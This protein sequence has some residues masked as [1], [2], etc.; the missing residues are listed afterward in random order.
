MSLMSKKQGTR[1]STRAAARAARSRAME[2]AAKARATAAT[3]RRRASDTAA[4]FTPLA[5]NAR[6]TATR[7]MFRA[8]QWAAPRLDQA[9]QAVEKR[10]APGVADMLTAAARRIEPRTRRRRWPAFAAGIAVLAAAGG[11]AAVYLRSR[12]GQTG[13]Q[14]E[15][16]S[17]AAPEGAGSEQ[18]GETATAD[19]NGQVRTS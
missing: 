18:A 8:R 10:V 11:G 2:K 19:V 14:P 15:P 4:Q 13:A 3:A 16:G 17:A 7:G 6:V 9:S 1:A 5:E 12:Q